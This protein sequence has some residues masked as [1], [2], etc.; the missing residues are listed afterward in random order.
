MT[1]T[2]HVERNAA[3]DRPP[4][5]NM[6]ALGQRYGLVMAWLLMIVIFGVIEP[7]KFLTLNNFQTLFDSQAILLMLALAFVISLV[8]GDFDL[9]VTGNFSVCL[10]LIGRLN[11]VHHVGY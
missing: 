10:V 6:N 3:T 1:D 5:V 7:S 9:A 4:R 2:L 8:S 11:V